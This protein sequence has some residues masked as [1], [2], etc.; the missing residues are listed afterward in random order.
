MFKMEETGDVSV[1][2]EGEM[3]RERLQGRGGMGRKEP[4]G[5]GARQRGGEELGLAVG[6]GGLGS[7]WEP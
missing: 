5:R 1:Q 7:G 4:A 2:R 3:E 6:F